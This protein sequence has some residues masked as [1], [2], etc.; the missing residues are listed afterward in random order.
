MNINV[1][2]L[3]ENLSRGHL[4]WLC[5]TFKLFA[6]HTPRHTTQPYSQNHGNFPRII[7]TI[8]LRDK[9]ALIQGRLNNKT[10]LAT[11]STEEHGNI[12]SKAFIFPWIPWIPW[13]NVLI[14][15][16]LFLFLWSAE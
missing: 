10:P 14:N 8:H 3:D 4:Q 13:Q 16:F 12:T 5:F 6:D 1:F 15:A 2:Y 9:T 11:E 7:V